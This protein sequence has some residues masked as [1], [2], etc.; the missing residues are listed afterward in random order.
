MFNGTMFSAASSEAC[1]LGIDLF[2]FTRCF[3][4]FVTFFN[5][6][7]SHFLYKDGCWMV[8]W[9]VDFLF[10]FLFFSLLK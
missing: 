8:D 1:L 7:S 9:L 3:Y 10:F 6:F 4:L 5:L 2:D